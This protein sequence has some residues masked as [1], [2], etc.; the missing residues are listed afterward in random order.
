MKHLMTSFYLLIASPAIALEPADLTGVWI[1]PD[2]QNLGDFYAIPTFTF[3]SDSWRIA[4]DA[5][6]DSDALIGL[7]TL[8]VG[9]SYV[10]GGPSDSVAGAANAVFHISTRRLTARSEDATALFSSMG[11]DLVVGQALDLT[12][13]GC[14]FVPSVMA[15]G[16]EYIFGVVEG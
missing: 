4:F 9:G 10:L 6:S 1:A 11:C 14:G 5:C 7:F 12:E 16:I 8:D 2:V 15:S 13:K 3:T